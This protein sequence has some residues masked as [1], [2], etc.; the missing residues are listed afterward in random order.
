MI[1]AEL[2]ELKILPHVGAKDTISMAVQ[3][4][5]SVDVNLKLF[6]ILGRIALTGLWVHWLI[7]QDR[8]AA[9]KA[10]AQERM[11]RLTTMSYQL[12]N[13]NR[14]LFLP[15]MDQQAI[16][17]ALFLILVGTVNGN[18]IDAA[19]WLHQMAE[20]LAFT[21]QTHGRY[22]CVFTEYRDLLSHP[23]E[24]SDDYRKEATSGSILIPLVA[25]FL[26]ALNDREALGKLVALKKEELAHC[27]LQLWLP[28]ES[29]EEGLYLGRLDHGVALCDLPLSTTGDELLRIL[30]DACET[31]KDFDRLS[32][33][34][35]GFWPIVLTA[36]RH[37]RLPVPP[38][39]WIDMVVPKSATR[40]GGAL[41]DRL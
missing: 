14:A 21:V 18:K 22:P 34:G 31:S 12:I 17:I 1:A 38:Q 28:D 2:L 37:Y 30:S 41:V 32:A 4:R 5:S 15:I 8:D 7:E 6:D 24:R 39:F 23:R 40:V 19:A 33:I 16:E 13:N 27:T 35:S 3:T 36:C 26:S 10:A 25:A 11:V 29:S 20:S 9:R